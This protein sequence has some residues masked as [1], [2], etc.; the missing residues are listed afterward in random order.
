M[1]RPD[2][3]VAHLPNDAGQSCTWP[4]A[5]SDAGLYVVHGTLTAGGQTVDVLSHFSIWTPPAAGSGNPPAVEKNGSAL[6][7]GEAQSADG[8]VTLFWPAGAFSDDI[9]VDIAPKL[10]TS[11]P[12]LP[13][14]ATV[15]QVTAF[16]PQHPR[17]DHAARRDRRR[18]L[19]ECVPGRASAELG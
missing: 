17:A 1:T 4:F 2:G 14:D 3:S 7:A 18:P 6:A 5:T 13:S 15:V 10:A 12:S 16:T 9:V 8:L 11:F 19:R